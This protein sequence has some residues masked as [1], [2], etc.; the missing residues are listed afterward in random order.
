MPIFGT[1]AARKSVLYA[2]STLV[3]TLNLYVK[4]DQKALIC[5]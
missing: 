1:R 3:S 4:V 5:Y 2:S